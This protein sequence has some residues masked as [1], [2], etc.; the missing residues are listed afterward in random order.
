L[1]ENT[2]INT[3]K[4]FTIYIAVII[5]ILFANISSGQSLSGLTGLFRIPTAEISYDGALTA[6]TTFYNKKYQGYSKFQDHVFGAYITLGFIPRTEVSIRIT[7]MI[8]SD[9]TSHVMD[10]I[11]SA[12]LILIKEGVFIPN[13]TLGLQNPYSTLVAANHFNST[14]LVASKNI[15]IGSFLKNLS[16]T[17]GYG[18]DIIK[19]ADYEFIGAFGGMEL[20]FNLQKYLRT[21]L[22]L[23]IEHDAERLNGALKIKLF[24]TIQIMGGL[25]G[26]DAFSGNLAFSFTL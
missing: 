6:G 26:F 12:K 25:Q 24:D 17:A 20:T 9:Y 19:A 14:F 21:D 7:R 18:S 1:L 15:T 4:N 3:S 11:L 22:S 13:L 23:I 5:V 8:D 16:L 2:I 10:R